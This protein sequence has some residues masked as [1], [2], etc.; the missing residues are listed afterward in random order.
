MSD[1]EHQRAGYKTAGLSA[2]GLVLTGLVLILL[3]VLGAE[4]WH[5]PDWVA[6]FVRDLGLLLAAVMAG[7]IL[8]EK[9][10]RDEMVSSFTSQLDGELKQLRE[11]TAHETYRLLSERPPAATGI[12]QLSEVRRNFSGYYAWVNEQRP[13]DLFFAGRSV[14]HR[15]DADIRARTGA[16]AADVIL[17]RL[18]E[19][20][21]VYILFLDPRID[22]IARLAKEEGQTLNAML[23]DIATSLDI[24]EKIASLLQEHK[25][26]PLGAELSIRVY[27][28]VP[29]LAYHKQDAE[30]IVGF[31]F[32]SA[33]GSTS[34]A[35]ELVDGVTKQTFEEH[36]V[37][38]R[39]EAASN[40]IVEFE[41]ARGRPTYKADL[42]AE[43]RKAI[44]AATDS[45][46]AQ[47]PVAADGATRRR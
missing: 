11:E 37:R 39:S 25:D 15:I 10:L 26:L 17:R 9:L 5:W 20:S 47:Q 42:V 33:K 21:R 27:D 24:C 7:T 40:T 12:R 1:G 8:H 4:A 23:G 2:Y 28:R 46:A 44:Q 18:K 43:L 14:L 45:S 6:H 31:Y 3:S 36:F 13:Q 38:I 16:T 30:V 34:A 19:G 32:D 29:Y 35:Y 41:G 22:I